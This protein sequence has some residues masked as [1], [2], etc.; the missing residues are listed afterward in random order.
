[1]DQSPVPPISLFGNALRAL[2]ASPTGTVDDA[3]Q[4]GLGRQVRA[5]GGTPTGGSLAGLRTPSG[6]WLVRLQQNVLH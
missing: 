6:R 4:V 2:D 3:A 5:I 1:V